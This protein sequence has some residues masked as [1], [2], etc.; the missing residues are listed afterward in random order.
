MEN[1]KKNV[2]ILLNLYVVFFITSLQ[3]NFLFFHHYTSACNSI[4]RK[5]QINITCAL[6]SSL[7]HYPFWIHWFMRLQAVQKIWS[8]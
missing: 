8:S 7:C 3:I 2:E 5:I 1:I 6:K 4:I